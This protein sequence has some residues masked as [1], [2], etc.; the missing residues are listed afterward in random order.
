MTGAAL[1]SLLKKLSIKDKQADQYYAWWVKPEEICKE[2]VLI[3]EGSDRQTVSGAPGGELQQNNINKA[4]ERTQK[5]H[6]RNL[7]LKKGK[8]ESSQ[9]D[10]ILDVWQQG[11]EALCVC[12]RVCESCI[13]WPFYVITSHD[14]AVTVT[15]DIRF[16]RALLTYTTFNIKIRK[17]VHH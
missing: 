2:F 17:N 6:G 7:I 10:N 14:T 9:D 12:P 1:F 11:Q 4:M 16:Y 8:E 13:I 3:R 15:N 5:R